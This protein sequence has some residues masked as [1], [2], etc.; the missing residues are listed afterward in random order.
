MNISNYKLI[1]TQ[2]SQLSFTSQENSVPFII[3]SHMLLHECQFQMHL[4][5]QITKKSNIRL[6][7]I[8]RE[9]EKIS[10]KFNTHHFFAC[11]LEELV[12]KKL[13]EHVLLVASKSTMFK[14]Q[15]ITKMDKLETK[16][17]I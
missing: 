7:S 2:T 16:F 11:F 4:S 3:S 10:L 5:L 8:V 14:A 12:T 17:D 15:E 13:K 1:N 9:L 6:F